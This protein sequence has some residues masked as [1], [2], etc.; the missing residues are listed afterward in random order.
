MCGWRWVSGLADARSWSRTM[1]R[2]G[3]P[4][5]VGGGEKPGGKGGGGGEDGMAGGGGRADAAG[6][7]RKGEGE[8]GAGDEE[9]DR[10]GRGDGVAEKGGGDGEPA[11]PLQVTRLVSLLAEIPNKDPVALLDAQETEPGN[12]AIH[13]PALGGSVPPA[14]QPGARVPSGAPAT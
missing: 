9:A 6:A 14:G 10:H 2:M 3:S 12:T 8:N 7:P 13:I 5:G 1:R 11:G 4:G